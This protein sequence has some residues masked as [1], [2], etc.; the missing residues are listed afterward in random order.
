[1]TRGAATCRT[2]SSTAACEA[3]ARSARSSAVHCRFATSSSPS[4][5]A[6][7]SAVRR[8]RAATAQPPLA[9]RHVRAVRRRRAR[10]RCGQRLCAPVSCT[11]LRARAAYRRDARAEAAAFA[12]AQLAWRRAPLLT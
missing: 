9:E 4:A 7:S 1:M 5:C 2:T 10:A 11:V 3:Q 8:R 12:R 6:P